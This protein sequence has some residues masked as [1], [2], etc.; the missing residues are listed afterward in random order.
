MDTQWDQFK[1]V[2]ADAKQ[3]EK[4]ISDQVEQ[5]KK[6]VEDIACEN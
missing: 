6:E 3:E 2:D 1:Q 4:E 5:E